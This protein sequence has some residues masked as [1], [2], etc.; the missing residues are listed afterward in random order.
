MNFEIA[1]KKRPIARALCLFQIRDGEMNWPVKSVSTCSVTALHTLRF[2]PTAPPSLFRC[3]FFVF[4]C[5]IFPQRSGSFYSQVI[6]ISLVIISNRFSNMNIFDTHLMR[7][8]HSINQNQSLI[9]HQT[10]T[11]TRGVTHMLDTIIIDVE[12][13]RKQLTVNFSKF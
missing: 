1:K 11:H 12:L 8:R 5:Y 7:S 6:S 9:M 10:P 2:N 4:F 13:K 3:F